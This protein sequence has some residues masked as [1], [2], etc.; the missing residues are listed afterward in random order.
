MSQLP[1]GYTRKILKVEEDHH[2]KRL[3]LFLE[4]HLDISRSQIKKLIDKGLVFVDERRAKKPGEKVQKGGSITVLI[5][6]PQPSHLV[7]KDEKLEILYEDE[8]VAVINKPAGIPVHPSAGHYHDT[9]ANILIAKFPLISFAGGEERPGIVHR[10]D[11]DTSGAL[12]IAKNEKAHEILSQKLKE[13]KITKIYLA[14]C[15]GIP[16]PLE[17]RIEAPISRH[18]VDRKKMAVNVKGRE[19]ITIYKTIAQKD[20]KAVVLARIIT[21]RTHQIRV[22]FHH[23][24]FPILGDRVYGKKGLDLIKR[25]A[26]HAIYLGFDHPIYEEKIEVFCRL[27]D[28]IKDLLTSLDIKLSEDFILKEILQLS[29]KPI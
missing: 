22:H 9:L 12:I 27:P 2:K 11:K 29:S 6:E 5:P 25:Q 26:L 14:V 17:G 18:P 24:S 23:K 1:E 21:G 15:E 19:A 8:F 10:L 16:N 3:D 13:K 7:P 4:A 28:D 20:K